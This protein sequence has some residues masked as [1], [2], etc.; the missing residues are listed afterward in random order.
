MKSER[1]HREDIVRYGR[2]LHEK[3]LVSATDGNLSV[4]LDHDT[5]LSTPTSISKGMMEPEDM[6]VVD[7]QG[8]KVMGRRNVSSEIAMH[9][10]I[11][12]LRPDIRGVVHA[13]PPTATGY[14]AAGLPLNQALVSEIVLSLGCIPLARY[15]TPGTPEL[16]DALAPL[17]PNYDAILMANHGV[18]TYADDLLRAYM[19]ME[20]VEHFARIALVS[21]QLGRQQLLSQ[22]DVSKLMIAREKYEATSGS[23]AS[24]A[25]NCPVT[26]PTGASL[27]SGGS[28]PQD[29]F[30]VTREE[31]M[32]IVEEVMEDS[33]RH[34]KRRW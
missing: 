22:E 30:L 13:H 21:H 10:L 7:M 16:T 11:Y 33:A 2:L 15:G 12:R 32:G 17:V 18:V 3:F 28:A 14:A 9:L 19:K 34:S 8:R 29:K 27:P 4:R 6:V 1:Q 25:A 5:I 31:L 26:A 20:T 24:L 23:R